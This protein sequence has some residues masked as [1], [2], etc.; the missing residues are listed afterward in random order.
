MWEQVGLVLAAYSV[1][2]TPF[3]FGFYYTLPWTMIWLDIGINF[4]FFADL[5]LTFFRAVQDKKTL[6]LIVDFKRI[7]IL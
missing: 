4:F 6:T 2:I 7:A 5:I 3:H 1:A